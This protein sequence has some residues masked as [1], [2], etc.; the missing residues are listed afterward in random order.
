MNR[1]AR[2]FLIGFILSFAL[3]IPLT[4]QAHSP[5]TFYTGAGGRWPSYSNVYFLVRSGFPSSSYTTAI[6]N[7]FNQWNEAEPAAI[8]PDFFNNGSTTVTGNA[9]APCSATYNGIYW[10]D[11]DYLGPGVLGY[12][13][14][15]E[16]LSGTVTRFS[17]SIDADR[18]WYAG[19]GTPSSS[20]Y[21]LFSVVSHE[22]GHAT[23]WAGHFSTTESIC[24][25][26]ASQA[27]MCPTVSPGTV[28]LRTLS[29]H[30]IHT[31]ASAY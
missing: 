6:N 20:Q 27:T 12:T 14:H 21:D 24:D 16:N 9:D 17:M 18:A 11:L 25:D 10:R 13:P 5:S 19:T 4:A 30:D 1:N 22:G 3:S 28:R 26:N 15:C 23:G 29:T 7:G 2:T 31:F 8:G